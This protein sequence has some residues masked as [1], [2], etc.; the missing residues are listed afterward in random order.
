MGIITI[1]NIHLIFDKLMMHTCVI[2]KSI[3]IHDPI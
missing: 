1:K 3:G 2:G